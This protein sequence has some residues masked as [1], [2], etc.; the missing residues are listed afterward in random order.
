[1]ELQSIDY[2]AGDAQQAD[3]VTPATKP[4]VARL[5]PLTTL[6]V[7]LAV[8]MLAGFFGRPLV[9]PRPLNNPTVVTPEEAADQAT[10]LP[11]GVM[12]AVV[13]QTRHFKGDAQAPIT[14]IEFGDFQ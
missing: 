4:V 2:P 3:A 9:T 6:V 11:A 14:I 5:N 10:T 8:G 1:M 7:G 12:K 13:A